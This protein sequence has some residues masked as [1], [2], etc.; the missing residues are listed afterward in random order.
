[1]GNGLPDSVIAA[2]RRHRVCSPAFHSFTPTREVALGAVCFMLSDALL[3]T[4]RFVQPLP[5]AQLWVLATYYAAQLLI[6]GGWM[7]AGVSSPS[8][9]S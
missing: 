8:A 5:L 2:Q 7:R 3:A 9:R 4:N 6:V 1:M